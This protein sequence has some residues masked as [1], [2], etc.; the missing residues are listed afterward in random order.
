MATTT[1]H[2]NDTSDFSADR[3]KKD[4][5]E[6]VDR[7]IWHS[8]DSALAIDVHPDV[9]DGI[10]RDILE[11]LDALPPHGAEVGGLLLGTVDQ[12]PSGA[13]I[14]IERYHRIPC[15]HASGPEFI[16][17]AADRAGLEKAAASIIEAS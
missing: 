9:M 5:K 1:G 12:T 10:A 8:A 2:L 14:R 3:P 6:A 11:S 15:S 16:L 13:T 7:F 4:A 17:D